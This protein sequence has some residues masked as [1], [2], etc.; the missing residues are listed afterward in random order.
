M[1]T[2]NFQGRREKVYKELLDQMN[3]KADQL[4]ESPVG[5]EMLKFFKNLDSTLE[6]AIDVKKIV[7]LVV[8]EEKFITCPSGKYSDIFF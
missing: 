6:D 7:K 5:K 2:E 1:T 4:S 8:E 3:Q